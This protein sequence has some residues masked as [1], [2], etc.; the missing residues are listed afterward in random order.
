MIFIYIRKR[1]SDGEKR[2]YVATG[3]IP[4]FKQF[5]EFGAA[6]YTEFL[7]ENELDRPGEAD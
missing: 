1:K 4:T 2:Y 7:E 3:V 5:L 6:E